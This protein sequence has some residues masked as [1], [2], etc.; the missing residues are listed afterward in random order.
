MT[1]VSPA[2]MRKTLGRF[3]TGVTVIA[4]RYED[5]IHAMTANAFMSV[6]L[7]PPLVLVSI[8]KR[9]RMRNYLDLPDCAFSIS[10]LESTQEAVAWHFAGRPFADGQ[11]VLEIDKSGFPFVAGAIAHVG[12]SLEQVHDVGDHM[13]YIGRVCH[14]WSR[15]GEPLLFHSGKFELI[16]KTQLDGRWA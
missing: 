11:K 3:C 13:L 5:G 8:D 7:E 4:T 12:C 14:L 10:V 9:A 16:E 15:G 6:S 2:A 1:D